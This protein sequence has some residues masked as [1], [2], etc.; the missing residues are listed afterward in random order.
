MER[1]LSRKPRVQSK[2]PRCTE[3]ADGQECGDNAA[4]KMERLPNRL[5]IELTTATLLLV[6]FMLVSQA[7]SAAFDIAGRETPPGFDLLQTF[8]ALYTVGYWIEVDNRRHN[9]KW[10]YCQGIFLYVVGWFIVPYYLFKTRGRYAFLILILFIC[11]T[12]VFSFVG[13]ILGTLF[14]GSRFE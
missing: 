14:F 9:F 13:I 1:A 5:G 12:T 10:P 11:L 8:G 3:L 4:L 7:A 6:A 2:R